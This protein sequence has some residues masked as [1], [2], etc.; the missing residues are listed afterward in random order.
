MPH[1]HHGFAPV[2]L[3]TKTKL[4]NYSA[5]TQA[6]VWGCPV[7]VLDP[8][9]QDG[10]KLP[11]WS[12]RSRRGKFVG[13]SF[14][15]AHSVGRI[16]N[17][18]SGHVSPQYH[19]VYD[20]H[21]TTVF[22]PGLDPASFNPNVWATLIQSGLERNIDL[23]RDVDPHTG[24]VAFQDM[25]ERFIESTTQTPAHG[26]E[27]DRD[28]DEPLAAAEPQANE[29]DPP[30]PPPD[31]P[32]PVPPDP[33]DPPPP[34]NEGDP[35][36]APIITTRS[37]RQVR[38]PARFRDANSAYHVGKDHDPKQRI[39]AG[40]ITSA[41]LQSLDWN[42]AIHMLRSHDSKALL[43]KMEIDPT[44]NTIE[45]MHPMSLAA[46][47]NDEDNPSWTEAMNGPLKEGF[48]EACEKEIRGLE[49]RDV[50]DIA[51]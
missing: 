28:D 21:F 48:W 8:T 38:K 14:E 42:K 3:F 24:R 12:P 35:N 10:R 50:W 32:N 46:K 15:H 33:P 25:F 43:A 49:D 39:R 36:K 22:N 37:G 27:G 30:A 18:Q 44:H 11:K 17:L 20:E 7:Y 31:P 4:P 29:G 1:Y 51:C 26:P 45:Y 34:V 41:F 16:L 19:V 9:L 23:D 40:L 2:E 5:I 47:A 6:R 13:Y